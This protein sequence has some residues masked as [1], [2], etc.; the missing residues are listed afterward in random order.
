[1]QFYNI[2]Y[3]NL[4]NTGSVT[5][6]SICLMYV[7]FYMA[8]FYSY[9]P[10]AIYCAGYE[11]RYVGLLQYPINIPTIM[12]FPHNCHRPISTFAMLPMI[13]DLKLFKGM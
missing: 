12:H 4:S 8:N 10:L 7:L 6:S 11:R 3:K 13:D 2:Y 5:P 1:M 9:P